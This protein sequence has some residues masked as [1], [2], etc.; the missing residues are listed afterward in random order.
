MGLF[1]SGTRTGSKYGWFFGRPDAKLVRILC[2]NYDD[3]SVLTQISLNI[4][5]DVF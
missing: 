5:R 3:P 4:F 2:G 1:S